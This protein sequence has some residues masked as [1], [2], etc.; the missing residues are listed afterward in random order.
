MNQHATATDLR[1]AQLLGRLETLAELLTAYAEAENECW[2]CLAHL[3]AAQAE[4][5]A[6]ARRL[7]AGELI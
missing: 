1:M 2:S 7:L 4:A 6:E 5:S 3:V